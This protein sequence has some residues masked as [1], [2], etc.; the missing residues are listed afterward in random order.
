MKTILACVVTALIVVTATA[1]A[2]SLITGSQIADN[3]I[4]T[5]NIHKN[6]ITLNRLSPGVQKLL[7]ARRPERLPTAPWA[8]GLKGDTGATGAKGDTR[9]AKGDT[10]ANGDTWAPTATNGLD[11]DQPRVV[12]GA[13]TQGFLLAPY[14][15]NSVVDGRGPEDGSAHGVVAA[16][17]SPVLPARYTKALEMSLNDTLGRTVDTSSRLP[18]ASTAPRAVLADRRLVPLAGRHAQ[19]GRRRRPHRSSGSRSKCSS[20][21]D[22][23][24]LRASRSSCTSRCYN[25]RGRQRRR[26]RRH[27]VPGGQGLVDLSDR[28]QRARRRSRSP[29]RRSLP[30]TRTRR[31]SGSSFD[32][33]GT[34]GAGSS[35]TSDTDISVDNAVAGFGSTFAR[36]DFGG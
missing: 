3:T 9:R 17:T 19:R 16:G 22:R 5:H 31:S 2:A 20:A 29:W 24:G 12:T 7:N 1:T 10:G 13:N 21:A 34:S 25:G 33:G 8:D 35:A 4:H 11:A 15:A 23:L 26:R 28:R 30:A 14:G 27:S 6:A 18:R 36:Y 32:N